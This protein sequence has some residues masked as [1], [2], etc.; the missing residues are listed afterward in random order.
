MKGD[1]RVKKTDK[2][3]SKKKTTK[4]PKRRPDRVRAETRRTA[5]PEKPGGG[6]VQADFKAGKDL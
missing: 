3:R 6:E 2:T 4:T 1:D 5:P